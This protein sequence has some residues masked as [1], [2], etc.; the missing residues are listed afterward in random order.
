M[1]SKQDYENYLDQISRLETIMLN[2]YKECADRLE[3]D[4]IKKVCSMLSNDE[5]QHELIIKELIELIN[6]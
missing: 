3:D 5:I 4:S 2:A 1:L 6:P